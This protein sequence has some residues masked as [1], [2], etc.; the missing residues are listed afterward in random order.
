MKQK[1]SLPTLIFMVM[2]TFSL[3]SCTEEKAQLSFPLSAEIF[4]SIVDKQVAFTAL[5][6]SAVSWAWDF[7]DGKSSTEKNPVHVYAE[8]GY[9]KATLT[10]KDATGASVVKEVK[11]AIALTQY[12]L[13]TGDHTDPNYK[14]KTWKLSA[15]H[16]THGDY[17][18]TADLNLTT[19][20]PDITPLPTGAF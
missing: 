18:A 4:K 14:G 17:L 5:T 16:S 13:L 20:D 8:G 15:D 1:L 3:S 10:A 11:L 19:M 12:A 2:M 9:Y 7:G 6:H